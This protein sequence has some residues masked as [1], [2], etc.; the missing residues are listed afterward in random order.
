LQDIYSYVSN[1]FISHLVLVIYKYN[2]TH[3]TVAL[4]LYFDPLDLNLITGQPGNIC[5]VSFSFLKH[6]VKSSRADIQTD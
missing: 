6:F 3:T 1:F 5:S 2:T 4:T